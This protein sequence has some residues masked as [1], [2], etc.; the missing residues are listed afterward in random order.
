MAHKRIGESCS[1]CREAVDVDRH[2]EAVVGEIDIVRRL[3]LPDRQDDVDRLGEQ[4]V[5]VDVEQA[6]GF[7]VRGERTSR[8]AEDEAPLRAAR[9]SALMTIGISWLRM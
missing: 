4:L 6:D 3:A 7:R 5:A 2:L 9:P 8:H 1:S